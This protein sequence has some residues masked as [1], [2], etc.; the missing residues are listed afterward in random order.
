MTG[1]TTPKIKFLVWALPTSLAATMG[2][3]YR[4]LFLCLLRCVT[5]A[6]LASLAYVFSYRWWDIIPIGF[7]H[8]DI[9]GSTPFPA[10]RSFSQVYTSFFAY[11]YQG[12]HQQPLTAWSH[13]TFFYRALS[14][15][16][17]WTCCDF[18]KSILLVTLPVIGKSSS[19]ETLSLRFG[20][21]SLSPKFAK[22]SFARYCC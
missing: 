11:R 9:S 4:F 17:I 5:S 2:I 10:L 6:G 14:I 21:V 13:K 19:F 16:Q 7:P 1:P 15:L 8:S 18:A 20:F 3:S 22:F 12:I